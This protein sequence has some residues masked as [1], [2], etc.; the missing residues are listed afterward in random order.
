MTIQHETSLSSI[1]QLAGA[2]NKSPASK[3]SPTAAELRAASAA[4]QIN[5][6][7]RQPITLPLTLT[8][9][10]A[11]DAHGNRE[12]LA[13]TFR[14]TDWQD[15]SAVAALASAEGGDIF[16]SP[17][18]G[19]K[20]PYIYFSD[21]NRQTLIAMINNGERLN[22]ENI[23]ETSLGR[24]SIA[25][26]LGEAVTKEVRQIAYKLVSDEYN[27]KAQAQQIR[28]AGFANRDKSAANAQGQAPYCVKRNLSGLAKTTDGGEGFDST[29]MPAPNNDLL[30]AARKAVIEKRQA[31]EAAKRKDAI[32]DAL[33]LRSGF[34]YGESPTSLYPIA[35]GQ[36]ESEG[37]GDGKKIDILVSGVMTQYGFSEKQV[38]ATMCILSPEAASATD[39]EAYVDDVLKEAVKRELEVKAKNSDKNKANTKKQERGDESMN[40]K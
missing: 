12:S 31:E 35:Y 2:S 18:E 17:A 9:L 16:V 4:L 3:A 15:V 38:R 6:Y 14:A 23:I 40:M 25:F 20:H 26:D 7:R 1:L 13:K 27:V 21:L 34:G 19:E 32:A 5:S 22:L 39:A 33:K 24:Y 30:I 36:K 10:K 37:G 8:I 28:V 11:P 29:S